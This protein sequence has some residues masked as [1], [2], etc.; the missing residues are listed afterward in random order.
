MA[1]CKYR[2]GDESTAQTYVNKVVSAHDALTATS[3]TVIEQI[4]AIRK[5]TRLPQYFAFLKRNNLA[6]TELGLKD[7]QL[8]WAIPRDEMMYNTACEQNAGY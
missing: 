3:G 1:E 7:Y 2:I 5:Q 8:L 6:A 4:S